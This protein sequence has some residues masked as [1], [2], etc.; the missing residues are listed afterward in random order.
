MIH[1]EAGL[2]L[3]SLTIGSEFWAHGSTEPLLSDGRILSV[4]DYD[5]TWPYWERHPAGDELVYVVA[6]CCELQLDDG[7]VRAVAL[8]VGSAVIVPAG[9]WHR[10]AF[11]GACRLLFVTP[12]PA[13]TEQRP[14]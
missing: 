13:R 10:A 1:L 6:G 11:T 2:D 3:D 8:R 5:T 14:A 4:F 12:T 9:V 7:D